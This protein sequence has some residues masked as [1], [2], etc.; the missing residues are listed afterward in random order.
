MNQTPVSQASHY[1]A[2]NG[3]AELA[4]SWL[5]GTMQLRGQSLSRLQQRRKL[6]NSRES[7]KNL[8]RDMPTQLGKIFTREEVRHVRFLLGEA[9]SSPSGAGSRGSPGF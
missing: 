8:K 3:C 6:M 5:M 2:A 7:K 4:K 9:L 1:N